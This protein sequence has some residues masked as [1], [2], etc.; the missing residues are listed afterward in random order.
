MSQRIDESS[1]EPSFREMY[2][3]A[4]LLAK[5]L[6]IVELSEMLAKYKKKI[7]KQTVII[8]DLNKQN[9]DSSDTF[10]NEI[11][12]LKRKMRWL[13]VAIQN[14]KEKRSDC[15]NMFVVRDNT[16]EALGRSLQRH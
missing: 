12:T 1:N 6:Q 16:I 2:L 8:S 5:T 14:V 10:M 4:E 11:E 7:E 13:N 3:T 9:S 15:K